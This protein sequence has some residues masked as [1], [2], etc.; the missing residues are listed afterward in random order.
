MDVPKKSTWDS[1]FFKAHYLGTVGPVFL[2]QVLDKHFL[3]FVL[4]K[5]ATIE[6]NVTF[7]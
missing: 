6:K 1:K 4:C 3:G 5:F 7:S 2:W